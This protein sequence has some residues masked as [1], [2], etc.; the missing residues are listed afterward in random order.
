MNL[1]V[2]FSSTDSEHCRHIKASSKNAAAIL[3]II[4]RYFYYV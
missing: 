4:G 2:P 1:N 3:Q